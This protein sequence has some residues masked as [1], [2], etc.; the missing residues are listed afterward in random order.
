M[1]T[2]PFAQ[3]SD[4][5]SDGLLYRFRLRPLDRPQPTATGWPFVPGDEEFVI[6]CVFSAPPGRDG[7]G[8]SSSTAPARPRRARPVSLPRRRPAAAPGR[9]IRVF[10]GVRWD[11][12]I[13][14]ARGG[15]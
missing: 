7:S 5:F 10:A 9:G 14:D 13:M 15:A 4:L 8:P 12:F 2:L 3:P 1:N 6:D 11:P